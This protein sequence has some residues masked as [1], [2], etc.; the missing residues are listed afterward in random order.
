M[1]KSPPEASASRLTGTRGVRVFLLFLA[2]GFSTALAAGATTILSAEDPSHEIGIPEAVSLNCRV[3]HK[4]SGFDPA[5]CWPEQSQIDPRILRAYAR[6]NSVFDLSFVFT[7]SEAFI[8]RPEQR[9]V[10]VRSRKTIYIIPEAEAGVVPALVSGIVEYGGI[11]F[12]AGDA[13][14]RVSIAVEVKDVGEGGHDIMES[15]VGGAVL[16]SRQVQSSTSFNL[17]KPPSVNFNSAR[18]DLHSSTPF[19]FSVYLRRAIPYEIQV[20]LT[21]EAEILTKGLDATCNFGGTG[22]IAIR[23]LLVTIDDSEQKLT[24]IEEGVQ[25]SADSNAELTIESALASDNSAPIVV[26][27]LPSAQGGQLEAVRALV[28][29]RITQTAASGGR[30]GFSRRFLRDG[31]VLFAQGDYKGAYDAYRRAYR[32]LALKR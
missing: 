4:N 22:G 9:S 16:L 11:L 20:V 18:A 14:A 12:T 1:Q 19:S 7:G 3:D 15:I 6:S 30:I 26:F 28:Q 8:A 24:S 13:Y 31:N 29:A 10:E 27:Q 23:S 21:C 25:S 2:L 5:S 17:A 32:E